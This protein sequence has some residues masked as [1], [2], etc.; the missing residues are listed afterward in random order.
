[1]STTTA[2]TAA[3]PSVLRDGERRRAQLSEFL[4][5]RREAIEPHEVGLPGGGR[6]R[7][8]GLRRE[9]VAQLAGVGTTWYTWLEQGR[10]VRASR[11]VLEAIADALRMTPAE[12]SHLIVLGRGE[13]IVAGRAPREQA[14][15]T[16]VRLIENLGSSPACILGRRWDFLTWND[17]YAVVF[18]DPLQL[19]PERR[20]MIWATFAEPARR[21]LFKDWTEGAQQVVA[22]FRADSARHVGDPEFDEL[23][24]EL[25]RGSADFN[26]WWK[27]HE[28]VRSGIGRKLLAHPVAGEMAFEH[29]VFKLE[30]S[31]EQRLVLYTPLSDDETAE[32]VQRLLGC[33][34]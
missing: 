9:E 17:A 5:I 16:L 10:D 3:K 34:Q 8:P 19:A 11:S 18:G 24:E 23:I 26:R 6:R 32:K 29:A 22:R 2:E 30:E 1:M 33:R 20:N 7:T 25:K 27:R 4:R 15:Q 14:S 21:T 12:R 31:P 13:E 28:V